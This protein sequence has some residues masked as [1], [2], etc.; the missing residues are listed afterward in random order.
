MA[1]SFA[2]WNVEK[3]KYNPQRVRAVSQLIA[4]HDPDVIGILEFLDKNAARR[5]VRSEHLSDYDFAFT[6]SAK[7]IEILVGWRRGKFDQV[8]YTQRR[9]LQVGNVNLRPGGLLSVLPRQQGVF[10]NF[11]FLHTDSGKDAKAFANRKLMFEKVWGLQERLAALPEQHNEARL[12]VLGDLNTMGQ[13]NGASAAEEI[14]ALGQAA[15][16]NGMR[17]LPK[18][19]A[20][21]WSSDGKRMS[22]LDHVIASNELRFTA[23]TPAPAEVLVDGWVNR[24]G[25]DRINFVKNISDHSLLFG[26]VR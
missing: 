11:L 25:D 7:S 3:F 17:V 20:H 18:S 14:A 6:D 5:L 26:E 24:S 8:L 2:V 9:E 13:T 19:H 1:C 16:A 10:T 23:Q 22:N 4:K 21:T 12:I 15:L